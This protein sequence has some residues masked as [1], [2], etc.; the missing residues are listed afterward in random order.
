MSDIALNLDY[1]NDQYQ[2][3]GSPIFTF[4]GGKCHDIIKHFI[5]SSKKNVRHK[6]KDE[7]SFFSF[8]MISKQKLYYDDL[9]PKKKS[10]IYKFFEK[11]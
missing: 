10:Q 3:V 2:K 9:G 7:E 1:L 5:K 8:R 6:K 4:E 11:V